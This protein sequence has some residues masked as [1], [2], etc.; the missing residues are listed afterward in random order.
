MVSFLGFFS[1]GGD[2]DKNFII[3]ASNTGVPFRLLIVGSNIIR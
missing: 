1:E 3:N 2:D